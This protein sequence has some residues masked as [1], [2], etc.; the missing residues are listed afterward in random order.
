MLLLC[1]LFIS[2]GMSSLFGLCSRVDS[3]AIDLINPSVVEFV[4]L[5]LGCKCFLSVFC[6]QK[7]VCIFVFLKAG[8]V[9][10]FMSSF[11]P[12]FVLLF[13]WLCVNCVQLLLNLFLKMLVLW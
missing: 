4:F 6:V 13:G 9:S 2:F 5:D 7:A 8:Y 10:G 12:F 3:H 11:F 1:V